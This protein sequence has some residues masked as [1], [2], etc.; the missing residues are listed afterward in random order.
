MKKKRTIHDLLVAKAAEQALTAA[1]AKRLTE[2]SRRLGHLWKALHRDGVE[3]EWWIWIESGQAE[4]HDLLWDSLRNLEKMDA[5]RLRQLARFYISHSWSYWEEFAHTQGRRQR[6]QALRRKAGHEAGLES[7]ASRRGGRK[8]LRQEI[9]DLKR[10]DP[11]LTTT[12]A[13]IRKYLKS[14]RP[15]EW[16]MA[17]T[18][19]Q[20][21]MVEATRARLT[22]QAKEK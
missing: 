4:P 9:D 11:T 1:E 2:H 14:Q 18:Q 8:L 12:A 10:R 5:V 13:A 6:L 7:G 20:R 21:Q 3:Y 16:R 15:D 19:K 17:S 22:R